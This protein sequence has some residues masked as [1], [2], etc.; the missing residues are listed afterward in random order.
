ME[1]NKK[2]DN[3]VVLIMFFVIV[4]LGGFII[5]DKVLK[6]DDKPVPENG[7]IVNTTN[8]ENNDLTKNNTDIKELL[9]MIIFKRDGSGENP[10][11]YS[12]SNLTDKDINDI[13]CSYIIRDE[14]F[15]D[16]STYQMKADLVNQAMKM[17]YG[18]DSN[19][20]NLSAGMNIYSDRKLSSVDVN[21]VKYYKA[22]RNAGATVATSNYDIYSYGLVKKM[23]Y[24]S[25]GEL[26]I[27]LEIESAVP[28]TVF[29]EVPGNATIKFNI[30]NGI[31][32]VS[33]E[34]KKADNVNTYSHDSITE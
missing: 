32:F 13:I 22:E 23:D 33:F 29:Y 28:E 6:K 7:N 18:K 34:Y 9:S 11:S 27:E 12:L 14:N 15:V 5:Y 20:F 31:K 21:G 26:I 2:K 10:S 17:V 3:V 16:D 24:T 25:N 1:E 4:L 30:N 19:S 8:N